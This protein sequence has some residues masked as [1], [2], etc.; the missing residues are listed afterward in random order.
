MKREFKDLFKTKTVVIIS[1]I[2][3]LLPLAAIAYAQDKPVEKK[4]LANGMTVLLQEST[5]EPASVCLFVKAGP[6]IEANENHGITR[7]LNSV[8]L[9][10]DP[11]GNSN[12]P[13]MRIE[14]AGAIISAETSAEY[15]CFKLV[16][17][18]KN[19]PAALKALGDVFNGRSI[20]EAS[21]SREKEAI[22]S[23]RL[24]AEDRF[25]ER[26]V[27]SYLKNTMEGS[28]YLFIT[29]G[30]T[31]TVSG[32]DAR[33]LN[34][35]YKANY[36]P[37]NMALSVCGKLNS[38]S[39]FKLAETSFNATGAD[40]PSAGRLTTVPA[41]CAGR[42][43]VDS[44]A[45]CSAVLLG[46]E[47]PPAGSQ[48]YAAV[49]VAESLLACGMG[50]SMFRK[51]RDDFVSAYG[52]GSWMPVTSGPSRLAIYAVAEEGGGEPVRAMLKSCMDELKTGAFSSDDLGRAKSVVLGR[53]SSE[54]ESNLGK[55][56]TAGVYDIM[57]LGQ[58]YGANFDKQVG[59]LGKD[60]IAKVSVRYFD[61]CYEVVSKPKNNLY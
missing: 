33:Q 39:V 42:L 34:A 61:K 44:P 43:E 15:S 12:P 50:S 45:G 7:L 53:A 60:E 36:Q 2:M 14:Q 11:L 31:G 26:V 49:A 8:L 22:A 1:V 47:A 5:D 37:G 59:K 16:V 9:S 30:D 23:H 4:L 35:W 24:R 56:W 55:A 48:D 17:P 32:L 41:A 29:E 10:I 51:L 54:R 46:Y 57:G 58:E 40:K 6:A 19:L 27:R 38:A 21:V 52:F 20:T 3:F 13:T 25:D 28:S 18:S